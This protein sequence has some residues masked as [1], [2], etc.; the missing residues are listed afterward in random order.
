[1]WLVNPGPLHL[2]RQRAF[3]GVA[4]HVNPLKLLS[5]HIGT[6][7]VGMSFFSFLQSLKP[8]L[9]KSV[10]KIARKEITKDFF[11][12]HAVTYEEWI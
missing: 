9:E 4:L 10:G 3:G 7:F 1:M 11:A 12:I 8:L 2:V 6:C 5:V